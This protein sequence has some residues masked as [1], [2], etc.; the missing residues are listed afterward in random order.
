MAIN[1]R[2][3]E[4]EALLAELKAATGKGAT[5]IVLELL[6]REVAFQR[7]LGNDAVQ[8]KRIDDISRT[9]RAK[10]VNTDLTDEEIIGYDDDGLPN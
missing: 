8:E 3:R 4:A 2:N 9:A 6:R 1:I 10:A 5:Q 7:R